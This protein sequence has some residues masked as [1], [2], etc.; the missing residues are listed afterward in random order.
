MQDEGIENQ[1]RAPYSDF[2]E[3]KSGQQVSRGQPIAEQGTDEER[4][5]GK[6]RKEHPMLTKHCKRD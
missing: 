1:K 3:C 5:K 6:I 4:K 2:K